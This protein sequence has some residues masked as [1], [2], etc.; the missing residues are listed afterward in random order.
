MEP[1]KG[2]FH[3]ENSRFWKKWFSK[4]VVFAYGRPIQGGGVLGASK[5]AHLR[6]VQLATFNIHLVIVRDFLGSYYKILFM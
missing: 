6:K 3:F 5:F 2:Q 4:K 1:K